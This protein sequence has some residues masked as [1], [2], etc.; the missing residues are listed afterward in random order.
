VDAFFLVQRIIEL[1]I[2]AFFILHLLSTKKAAL[3]LA[4]AYR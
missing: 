1:K 3:K 2:I 4:A